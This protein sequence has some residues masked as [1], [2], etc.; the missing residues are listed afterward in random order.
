MSV[1]QVF[2]EAFTKIQNHLNYS[3]SAD[4]PQL[5]LGVVAVADLGQ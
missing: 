3:V 5:E 2:W 4:L 1:L